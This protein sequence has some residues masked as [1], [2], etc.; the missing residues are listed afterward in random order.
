[1]KNDTITGYQSRI[2]RVLALLSSR[3]SENFS[4]E[5]LASEAALSPYHFHR[6]WRGVTGEPIG[7]TVRR[8]RMESARHALRYSRTSITQIALESGFG[9]S[10]SF[11]RAFR[12]INGIAPREYRVMKG[13][14]LPAVEPSGL[15][16]PSPL[17]VEIVNLKPF[18]VV[19]KRRIG[20][21]DESRLA[22]AFSATWD[23][24]AAQDIRTRLRGIYG[25]PY[26]DPYSVPSKDLRYD[27]CLDLGPGLKPPRCFRLLKL[28]GGEF[29]RVTMTGPYERLEGAYQYLLG[30]WLATA[31][32]EAANHP[33]FNHFL[34]D[35][36]IT[37]IA[38]RVTEVYVPLVT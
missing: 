21:Y 10:Q 27:A 34:S 6:V 38:E 36:D 15:D 24:A 1:M 30:T 31:G 28:G 16:H 29:A 8:L 7:E 9:S 17:V 2:Q 20:P 35:P 19:A 18:Q 37:P 3:L 22:K 23:W 11:S 32:R 26:D 4:L 13:D 12:T 33:L 5:R 25:I 14:L